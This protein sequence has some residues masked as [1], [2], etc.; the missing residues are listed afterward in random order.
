MLKKTLIICG[1]LV[2]KIFVLCHI[3]KIVKKLDDTIHR[4][5]HFFFAKRKVLFHG[6]SPM[7]YYM[8][9]PI[10]NKIREGLLA[11]VY[12]CFSEVK[13]NG[14]FVDNFKIESL[15]IPQNRIIA[16]CK[17]I[18]MKWDAVFDTDFFTP[19]FYR[20]TYLI[21]IFH[22]VASKAF[23]LKDADGRLQNRDYLCYPDLKR[24]DLAL[25]INELSYNRTKTAN[26]WKHK[27]TGE[28]VGMCCL[29]K[30][31][32][33][34]NPKSI[35][36]LK[37]KYIPEQ[38]RNKK[39]ILYAPTW[40]K[41]CSWSK[42]GEEI[43]DVLSRLDAFI[44]TKPHPLCIENKIGNGLVG[45]DEYLKRKFIHKN[46][47]LVV[48]YPYDVMCISDLMV[49]DFSS[50]A[51][52]YSLL[53]KP[54]ILFLGQA[55]AENVADEEQLKLLCKCCIPFYENDTLNEGM[56][57]IS[58]IT[59]QQNEAMRILE[60]KYFANVGKA[61]DVA[62]RILKERKVFK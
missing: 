29:D 25:F 8:F 1:K 30:M 4:I 52:E 45:L 55:L 27:N 35:F 33:S 58:K 12:F 19:W 21:Q 23:L 43:L 22:G 50:I 51:F 37:S 17:A 46:Y 39:V 36:E 13:K 61:T 9:E 28:I 2:L 26:L 59:N 40:G 7:N 47:L 38:Y 53:R 44:I 42:K 15:G 3:S 41:H 49:T 18:W 31:V 48:D 14:K 5:K 57:S 54:I 6:H 11:E 10:Y 56:L 34:N 60:N 62:M 16:P 20:N 24:Y 32:T